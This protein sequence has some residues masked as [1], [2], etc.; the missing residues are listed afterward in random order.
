MVIHRKLLSAIL[1][2]P[3]Y[4]FDTTSVSDD[5]TCTVYMHR[6]DIVL[7]AILPREHVFCMIRSEE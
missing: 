1:R 4:F 2:A 5:T 6:N 3:V 7:V